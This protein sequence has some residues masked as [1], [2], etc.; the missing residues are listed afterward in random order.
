M[1]DIT[2]LDELS[3]QPLT[4]AQLQGILNQI[5]LDIANLVREGKL[6]AMPETEDTG[7]ATDR[8]ANL[9][10]LLAAR[11]HYETLLRAFP[12]WEVSQAAAMVDPHAE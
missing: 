11:R 8:A 6:S 1:P 10:A 4:E 9:H 7:A 5:D 2:S 3:G 12:A